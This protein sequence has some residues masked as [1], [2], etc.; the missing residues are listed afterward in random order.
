MPLNPLAVR[1]SAGMS[2]EAVTERN[3]VGSEVKVTL[4]LGRRLSESPTAFEILM[5][6]LAGARQGLSLRSHWAVSLP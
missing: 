2:T 5:G 6:R 1:N 3:V 4:S